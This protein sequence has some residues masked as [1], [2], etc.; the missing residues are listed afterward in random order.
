MQP[1]DIKSFSE[2][3][4]KNFSW[5]TEQDDYKSL[6]TL[7]IKILN[8]WKI[9]N[10]SEKFDVIL[11]QVTKALIEYITIFY[12]IEKVRFKSNVIFDNSRNKFVKN[13][14]E[15]KEI[16][17]I[18]NYDLELK[19]LPKYQINYSISKLYLKFG[20]L[21]NNKLLVSKN[22]I[23]QNYLDENRAI[24][25]PPVY[26]LKISEKIIKK[27]P[28]VTIL[29]KQICEALINFNRI[30]EKINSNNIENI[31]NIYLNRLEADIQK[32]NSIKSI[33]NSYKI[34]ISGTGDQYFNQL[35]SFFSNINNIPNYRFDHGGEK[36]FFID[37]EFW[38]SEIQFI[39]KYYTYSEKIFVKS[40]KKN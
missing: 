1:F 28:K 18:Y 5:G 27:N 15:N 25:L 11:S 34:L 26:L 39:N 36:S 29:S 8:E 12:D 19:R 21:F 2:I 6:R 4:I 33:F 37:R 31:I 24:Y 22:E 13:I 32:L 38:N 40:K 3:E 16:F 17:E 35:T 23:I 30:F 20:S 14:L 7:I 9:Y 10:E